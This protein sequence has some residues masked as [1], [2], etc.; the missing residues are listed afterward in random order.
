MKGIIVKISK[1]S[2]Y[3]TPFGLDYEAK[4]FYIQK[5]NI[6]V[7]GRL[8]PENTVRVSYPL[9]DVNIEIIK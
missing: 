1:T 7:V 2:D 9:K 5:K 6:V 3:P 8:N 4:G